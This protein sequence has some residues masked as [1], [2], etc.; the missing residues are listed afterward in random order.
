MD[1]K[2]IVKKCNK[3][4]ALIRVFDDCK[5]SGDCG[6][7]CCG[8]KMQIIEP[9]LEG[10]S[11]EKHMPTYE[12]KGDYIYVK[13]NHVMEEE[14]YIKFISL[15]TE[16]EEFT[17]K[18]EP[19]FPAAEAKFPYIPVSIIYSYCNIHGIYKTEVN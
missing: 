12:K 5:C 9:N 10:A 19:S 13:L 3:C 15:V 17:L 8:E 14:H 2:L 6:I 4:G 1:N 7:K 11:L 16:H 18:L